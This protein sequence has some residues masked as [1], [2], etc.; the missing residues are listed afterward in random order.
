MIIRDL[1]IT[2]LGDWVRQW[3]KDNDVTQRALAEEIG[4]SAKHL[5]RVIQGWSLASPEMCVMISKV[6]GVDA[7]DLYRLQADELVRRAKVALHD[8]A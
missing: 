2:P 1:S 4:F 8:V 3:L 6:T 5:N 7:T